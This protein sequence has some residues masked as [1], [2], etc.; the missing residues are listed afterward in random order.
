M[1]RNSSSCPDKEDAGGGENPAGGVS[2]WSTDRE[3]GS[4]FG[5]KLLWLVYRLFG[6]RTLSF[7]LLPVSGYYFL[8][9][10]G[11]RR[12]SS[13][14]LNRH[15]LKFADDWS[16]SPGVSD[17]LRHF[18]EFAESVVDKLLAWRVPVRRHDFTLLDEAV[19][20]RT[21][22][23]SRGL[24][25]IGSHHGCIE[26]SRGFLQN[27]LDHVIN[28]LVYDRH[29]GNYVQMMRE[30]SDESRINIYQVDE[31]SISTM[32]LFKE[33]IERGEWIFVAG[34]RVPVSGTERTVP[35]Q[36]LGG[37]ALFPVGPYLLAHA[38]QCP[39]RL[40]FSWKNHTGKDQNIY[41]NVVEF[42]DQIRLPR[43]RDAALLNYAQRYAAE[44]EKVVR[45]APYQWFNFYDYWTSEL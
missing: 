5:L 20:R 9:R 8:T 25:I 40:M 1:S 22:L 27:D 32:L 13:Q 26:F 15:F 17:Q 35:V 42:S 6:R 7:L 23:D 43:Q 21:E 19:V 12:A 41:F 44:L 18:H 31:F 45:V 3:A 37:E 33:K 30:F 28:L 4:L 11:A 39:V 16:R 14:Y 10:S 24:L 38:L 29:S 34:D 2:S 36:F